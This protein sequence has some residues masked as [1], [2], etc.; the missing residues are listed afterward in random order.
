VP[1]RAGSG[2]SLKSAYCTTGGVAEGIV[3][4]DGVFLWKIFPVQR[5]KAN[6]QE[7]FEPIVHMHDTQSP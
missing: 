3:E 4:K 6:D 2:R 5:K 1:E 7:C